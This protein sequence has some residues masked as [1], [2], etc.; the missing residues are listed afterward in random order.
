VCRNQSW[1]QSAVN[2]QQ[3]RLRADASVRKVLDNFCHRLL[4]FDRDPITRGLT[5]EVAHEALL[6]V[7]APHGGERRRRC[8]LARMLDGEAAQWNAA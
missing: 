1:S 4:T 7:A 8:A 5:V 2:N 3:Y 6:R